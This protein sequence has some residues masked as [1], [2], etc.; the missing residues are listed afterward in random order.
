ML[1]FFILFLIVLSIGVISVGSVFAVSPIDSTTNIEKTIDCTLEEGPQ[2]D[3]YYEYGSE[4]EISILNPNPNIC[5]YTLE[6]YDSEKNFIVMEEEGPQFIHE[7]ITEFDPQWWPEGEYF[8]SLKSITDGKSNGYYPL[9]V[10]A[11]DIFGEELDNFLEDYG[12]NYHETTYSPSADILIRIL[13]IEGKLPPSDIHN[14]VIFKI[15]GPNGNV[16]F[17]DQIFPNRHGYFTTSL[18]L[19]DGEGFY[20][21][22][23]Y[24]TLL[25][26]ELNG[27]ETEWEFEFIVDNA[28]T[29]DDINSVEPQTP[30]E[31]VD[32]LEI[33][34]VLFALITIALIVMWIYKKTNS[35]KDKSKSTKQ[36]ENCRGNWI[37]VGA[38]CEYCERMF[39]L[40]DNERILSSTNPYDIL[41]ISRNSSQDKIKTAYHKLIKKYDPSFG[42]MNK[43]KAEQEISEK[44]AVKLHLAW[45]KLKRK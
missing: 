39:N 41:G 31:Y 43:T 40:P 42:S 13:T 21:N 6:F 32:S 23:A 24:T 10:T 34:G 37:S 19:A 38:I 4:L 17:I 15:I 36:C 7:I 28:S 9:T 45:E 33:I 8:I 25:T 44:I 12:I 18:Q 14:P 16:T 1:K 22:G 30:R 3:R 2:F 20:K 27:E 29:S 35:S 5:A 11:I 26:W